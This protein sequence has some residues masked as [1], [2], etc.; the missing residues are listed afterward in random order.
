MSAGWVSPSQRSGS[1]PFQD[2]W[3]AGQYFSPVRNISFILPLGNASPFTTAADRTARAPAPLDKTPGSRKP[4][5]G[6]SAGV[7]LLFPSFRKSSDFGKGWLCIQT[8]M[9]VGVECTKRRTIIQAKRIRHPLL[10]EDPGQRE[11]G[12]AWRAQ[13]AA[14][15][16]SAVGGWR[17]GGAS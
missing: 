8:R 6:R 11:G 16:G 12:G 17:G 13:G 15:R 9:G 7:S 14:N 2:R 5:F 4:A 3:E 1:L 10:P